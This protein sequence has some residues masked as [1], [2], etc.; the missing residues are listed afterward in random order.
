MKYEGG[1]K[2]RVE[3]VFLQTYCTVL[4]HTFSFSID[5]LF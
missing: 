5:E 1:K 3:D 4:T 2:N